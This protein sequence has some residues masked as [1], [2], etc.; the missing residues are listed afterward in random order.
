MCSLVGL[1]AIV[2]GIV[3]VVYGS[4]YASYHATRIDD[5]VRAR[6]VPTNAAGYAAFVAAPTMGAA[7]AEPQ[8]RS[9]YAFNITNIADVLAGAAL[10]HV[11]QVGPYVYA[12]SSLKFNVQT[13][14]SA[15]SYAVATTYQMDAQRSNGSSSDSIITVNTS[16]ARALAKLAKSNFSERLLVASLAQQRLGE[17][18]AYLAG[19]MIATTKQRLLPP[20]LTTM[21][22]A[23]RSKALPGALTRFQAQV[24][25][26]EL[27]ANLLHVLAVAR[28]SYIPSLLQPMYNAFLVN[29]V[30]TT[31]S[32]HLAALQQAS[33][34]RVLANTQ[35][36]LRVE[37][38]PLMLAQRQA[39]LRATAVPTVLATLLARVP[40]YT[41]FPSF[42][43]DM[44]EEACFE[45]VPSMLSSIKAGIVQTYVTQG[46]STA[47]AQEQTVLRWIA[48][49]GPWTDLDTMVGGNPTGSP[50]YGFELRSFASTDTS[51]NRGLS[52][53]VARLVLGSATNKDFSLV[54]YT[55]TDTTHGFG[56]WKRV[57]ALDQTAIAAVLAGV[58]NEVAAPA[59]FITS[60][61]VLGIRAYIMS[62]SKGAILHRD[63]QR[64]W[65]TS[66]TQR[67]SGSAS[68]PP[69]DIDWYTSGVQTGFPLPS[70][71]LGLSD[72]QCAQLWNAQVAPSFL[73]PV[74]YTTWTA[75]GAS[76]SAAIATL[77]TAFGLTAA[78]LN[79]VLAW[80][81]AL[82]TSATSTTNA[83]RHWALGGTCPSPFNNVTT[84]AQ[85]NLEPNA[86][87]TV[88]FELT[89]TAN[90][91]WPAALVA[92]LWDTTQTTSF[93]NSAGY[94]SWTNVALL[95]AGLRAMTASLTAL[96]LGGVTEDHVRQVSTW[97]V[98]WQ[99]HPLLVQAMDQSWRDPTTYPLLPSAT[100]SSLSTYLLNRPTI[101]AAA[102]AYFN[103]PQSA[104]SALNAAGY[105]TWM[106]GP[107]SGQ[108][109][110]MLTAINAQLSGFCSR[111]LGGANS[112]LFATPLVGSCASLVTADMAAL[113]TYV[114]AQTTDL[115]MLTALRDQWRCGITNWD[116]EPYRPGVELGLE[117]CRNNSCNLSLVNGTSC[118]VPV[119]ANG[120]WDAANALSFLDPLVY[121][122]TWL[123][124][125]SPDPTV[126]APAKAAIATALSLPAWTPWLDVVSQ[127][128]ASW[129]TLDYTHRDVLGLWLKAACPTP[130]V[131]S[132][133]PSSVSSANA[134]CAPST[135]TTSNA[136]Q[137]TN[138]L[139]GGRPTTYF[140]Q[141]YAGTSNTDTPTI[142]L[143]TSTA[144]VTCSG[145]TQTTTTTVAVTSG[146]ICLMSD[147]TPKLPNLQF[148]FEVGA[149]TTSIPS[150]L[151]LQLWDA[152]QPFSFL[153]VA[154]LAAY[155]VPAASDATKL[156]ALVAILQSA[157]PG[158]L[159][160]DVNVL[161]QWLTRWRTNDLMSL[162][163]LTQWI[164]PSTATT[165]FNLDPT[166]ATIVTGFELR[167]INPSAV[168]YP[169]LV[170]AQ[171]LWAPSNAY[172]FLNAATGFP[173]WVRAF[174]GS[175]PA[176]E[177]LVDPF[178]SAP[179]SAKVAQT[180]NPSAVASITAATGLTS[181]Q[182][183]TVAVWLLS[184]ANHPFL[185][186]TLMSQWLKSTTVFSTTPSTL[187][188]A[189]L[190]ASGQLPSLTGFEVGA[191]SAVTTAQ[192]AG[193]WSLSNATSFL[194]PNM[195]VV[196]CFCHPRVAVACPHLSD[197][198]GM[199][200]PPANASAIAA[201]TRYKGA[202]PSFTMDGGP[203]AAQAL[204]FLATATGISQV[205]VQTIAQWLF[206]VPMSSMYQYLLQYQ[207]ANGGVPRYTK[208]AGFELAFV[209]N[210]SLVTPRNATSLALVAN[211]PA[212]C[213]AIGASVA[214]QVWLPS[215]TTSF[216]N[217]AGLAAWL[218]G[219]AVV[220]GLL[221]CQKAQIAL[222]LESWK[223]HPYLRQYT[224]FMWYSTP[225]PCVESLFGCGRGF[226][227]TLPPA[228]PAMAMSAVAQIVWDATSPLSFL[229]PTGVQLWRTLL[230]ACTTSNANGTCA[231]ATLTPPSASSYLVA[232]F[233]TALPAM[234]VSDVRACVYLI[235]QVWLV[236]LLDNAG[237][238]ASVLQATGATTVPAL[239]M[240]QFVSASVLAL[241]AT[242][243]DV[244]VASQRD[245]TTQ[246][247][248]DA[249]ASALVNATVPVLSGFP[250][251]S[252]FCSRATVVFGVAPQCQLGQVYTLDSAT[253]R[254][255]FDAWNDRTVVTV[256]GLALARGVLV[257]DT[258]L[259]QPF[260]SPAA[261]DAQ[262]ARL[263]T[264]FPAMSSGSFTC[265][266]L[267]GNQGQ[268][269]TVAGLTPFSFASLPPVADLQAYLKY[270]ATVFG[271]R[272]DGLLGGLFVQ[273]TVHELLW[274]N[275]AARSQQP[276]ATLP[277][278]NVLF[279]PG[280]VLTTALTPN[281]SATGAVAS[282]A[283]TN[284]TYNTG[285]TGF[286]GCLLAVAGATDPH[287]C[288]TS[289]GS[290][291][292]PG[293]APS[294][295]SFFW[296]TQARYLFYNFTGVKPWIGVAARR[297]EDAAPALV[298]VSALYD[299]LPVLSSPPH[300]CNVT[301]T[302]VFA[303]GMAPNAKQHTR[304]L[305]LEPLSGTTV[306]RRDTW[307]LSVWAPPTW[308]WHPR[309][310]AS[311]VPLFWVVQEQAIPPAAAAS[312]RDLDQ[313]GPLAPEKVAIWELV[314]GLAVVGLGAHF[315]RVLSRAR[316]KDALLIKPV[317]EMPPVAN[318]ADAIDVDATEL[319]GRPKAV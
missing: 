302:T 240:L 264:A 164:D 235:G 259:A 79:G 193:L 2:S 62:W 223:S 172:S 143:S 30:P 42:A 168:T 319:D 67:T 16:Y 186:S 32:S 71:N 54:D 140:A 282:A 232:Q 145:G 224:E 252:A 113:V 31:L 221:A 313:P 78:Q 66:Y 206:Q 101:S 179:Q 284:Y 318:D 68:E 91:V 103:S 229:H 12:Q 45:A 212:S 311:Y 239:A 246:V 111:L 200:L 72:T 34:P 249:A 83:L 1:A 215:S 254:G 118:V 208:N 294:S 146:P 204:R 188:L 58:N 141:D 290:L 138:L 277:L 61:Q 218:Q 307:Q 174:T 180:A 245:I 297:Y 231:T 227:L 256:D 132:Q 253:A 19:P 43:R 185:W 281:V 148:G 144:V 17:Y 85:Y 110:T 316:H 165:P 121:A 241:N 80:I 198:T 278:T 28:Q 233:A 170:Q 195:L 183:Q 46:V 213:A 39:Q 22:Q 134:N 131:V 52:V 105:A 15:I 112:A 69:V 263:A 266:T 230:S 89:N 48:T 162:F 244:G 108:L 99:S 171:Y 202:Y 3:L 270:T 135:T 73:D 84:C 14:P 209:L 64:Y 47:S 296:Q 276:T 175:L 194:N 56:L 8:V 207:W 142:V 156:A 88:G 93:L 38:V 33:V 25:S 13:T 160:A 137:Y 10:P 192:A 261:C 100:I 6:A 167:F 95:P 303:S 267:P 305:D 109:A 11:E 21:A 242:T 169:T 70:S 187:N 153:N 304:L 104:Y 205:D 116:I 201:I 117:L 178:A 298:D 151:L 41:S 60:A 199:L 273:T 189:G 82:T 75:A 154:A 289:D 37:A 286:V 238:T 306:H 125:Q 87:S 106:A 268:L 173:A 98:M 234:S 139:V 44:M 288:T 226:E 133:T 247:R 127:W 315:L 274:G 129:A 152:S 65:A 163:A 301:S 102:A 4:I 23:V 29:Y 159:A 251:F 50:R 35:S 219:A 310:Q 293:E 243:G 314:L 97:L 92:N 5:V 255:L 76:N 26:Q 107:N 51:I 176:S 177:Y 237:F 196:W 300:L 150:A 126:S 269:L 122:S 149:A 114:Q 77:Q 292:T 9:Y 287:D 260:A 214:A 182:I 20:Y 262:S 181:A 210:S 59:D 81:Q 250:E 203:T 161:V 115:Y 86:A 295:L 155:W 7:G 279:G 128:L 272:P 166:G 211:S 119:A 57:V 36:R 63:R 157:S 147:V 228:A 120:F 299:D 123:P 285:G 220:P 18:E 280:D 225:S 312:F 197:A 53:D 124:V 40:V 24:G 275:P 248:W 55:A 257:L 94:A 216:L 309:V 27:P 136:T 236:Q 191:A 184:W 96:N 222:W 265:M 291:F 271:Y 130:T 317:A 258:F 308:L 158:V 217:A 190:D 49:T 90:L 74:G 283:V